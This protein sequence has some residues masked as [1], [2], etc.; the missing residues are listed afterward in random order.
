ME[1][2]DENRGQIYVKEMLLMD[3]END[4][5]IRTIDQEPEQGLIN[6]S[7]PIDRHFF[8]YLLVQMK[9][10][11]KEMAECKNEIRSLKS[12]VRCSAL[13]SKQNSSSSFQVLSENRYTKRRSTSTGKLQSTLIFIIHSVS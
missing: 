9:E 11:F 13:S 6:N 8:L 5:S 2:M 12:I 3:D 10:L 7:C 1:I 4:E